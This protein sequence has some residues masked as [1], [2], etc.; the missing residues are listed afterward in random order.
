M[1]YTT[2]DD[3]EEYFQAYAYTGDGN[4]GR[5]LTLPG[6]TDMAPNLVWV[7]QR[8]TTR[9]QIVANSVCGASK[10]LYADL[11]DPEDGVSGPITAF[12]S[13][14]FTVSSS[15]NANEDS[16]TY[17]SWSW[18]ESATGGFDIVTYT[19][20][21]TG[22]TISHSLSAAP[23]MYIIKNRDTAENWQVFHHK[24]TSAPETDYVTLNTTVGTAD[25]TLIA[26]DTM[27]TSS[28]FSVG[29]DASTN[30][31]SSPMVAFL[32][33]GIQG[34]S[35]FG[36]Y[37]GNGN[38]NGPMLFMGFS[39]A[40]ILC[41]KSS[42]SG[43]SWTI[44]DNKRDPYN[45]ADARLFPDQNAAESTSTDVG[46]FLSNGFKIRTDAGTWNDSDG[47]YLYAAFAE[48]PLVNSEGVPTTAR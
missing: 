24:N 47:T 7:K 27:P 16:G 42:A 23:H 2:I 43:D 29:T 22:R 26:N 8:N 11:N 46:D 38:T 19:G 30:K 6:D 44:L 5:A 13:D 33:T 18:N 3:P 39:P 34:F 9:N 37:T 15:A 20:N 31:S 45:V 40:W 48:A 17:A 32:F 35:K 10:N 41:K 25:H 4:S 21:G 12:G 14:G 36:S 1:A 28:V